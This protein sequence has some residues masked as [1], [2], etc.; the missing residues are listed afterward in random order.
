MTKVKIYDTT[1][2]DGTQAEGI[3]FS[4]EDKVRIAQRLDELGIHYIEG[5]WPGSNPKDIKFF[6]KMKSM[7]LKNAQLTAFGSTRRAKYPAGKD[8]NI[9]A[10]LK[11]GTK[12]VCIF[13]KSWDLHVKVAL[14]ISLEK[15][16]EL[17]E[18]S[19]SYLKKKKKEVV[20]DAEHF[21]DGYKDNSSYALKTLEA[22]Q[23][24]GADWI[25]L[26]DTNGGTLPFELSKIMREVR[27]K[28]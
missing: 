11:S 26:C 24:A 10:L 12:V 7:R 15:N 1:L 17:I 23:R 27:K 22:A 2:R 18:D 5:G 4:L 6:Q 13:G 16:L 21:F 28:I 20:Y 3:S 19:V 14:G 25:V 9:R 8:P